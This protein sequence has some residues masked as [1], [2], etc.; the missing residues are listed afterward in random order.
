MSSWN[1][2]TFA[3]WCS[4]G[5]LVVAACSGTKQTAEDAGMD[6]GTADGGKAGQGGH[7]GGGG[8]AG[9]STASADAGMLPL[10]MLM[11]TEAPPTDPVTCGGQTCMAPTN[12]AMNPCIVPCCLTKNGHEVCAS[13]ST[14]M[15]FSTECTLPATPDPSCPDAM[16]GALGTLGGMGTVPDGGMAAG[17]AFKGCCNES[18]HKCGIISTLRPG[19]VT[20]STLLM[21]PANPM[22]CSASDDAGPGQDGG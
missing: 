7:G 9:S 2:K 11:C 21:L 20:Q 3:L 12:Y 8:Q 1:G 10:M 17:T 22:T 16:G 15:G 19:C 18:M 4:L 13:K 5:A 14:A 6:G